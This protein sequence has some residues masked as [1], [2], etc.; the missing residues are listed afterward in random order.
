[1]AILNRALEEQRLE[2][3][4]PAA[5]CYD[6]TIDTWVQSNRGEGAAKAEEIPRPFIESKREKYA[7]RYSCSRHLA[8]TLRYS[9]ASTM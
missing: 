7:R 1:M 6:I 4:M 2:V 3:Q 5:E 8:A 9:N